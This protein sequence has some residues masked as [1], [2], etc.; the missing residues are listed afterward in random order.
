MEQF[1]LGG[2]F[3]SLSLM[4]IW[5]VLVIPDIVKLNVHIRVRNVVSCWRAYFLKEQYV[6]CPKIHVG[7]F[8]SYILAI[9]GSKIRL[10]LPKFQN[11]QS[12]TKTILESSFFIQFSFC[13]YQIVYNNI[14]YNNLQLFCKI[15]CFTV[16]KNA[17]VCQIMHIK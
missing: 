6:R 12:F 2:H 10:F 8:Y 17:F 4:E 11:R 1:E 7:H 15:K 5:R 13:L 16:L 9:N 3:I 14:A